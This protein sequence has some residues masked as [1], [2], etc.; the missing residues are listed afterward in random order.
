MNRHLILVYGT[1]RRGGSNAI[2]RLFPGSRFVGRAEVAG[3]LYD[4][5]EYPALLQGDP[6]SLVIGEVYEVDDFTLRSLDEFEATADYV[7]RKAT[8]N[9]GGSATPCWYYGPVPESCEG[10]QSIDSGDW[11]E[12]VRR[13]EQFSSQRP[14]DRARE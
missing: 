1:L 13:G 11:I 8:V 2:E 9:L 6:V 10:K 7:R 3:R 4:L 12:H 5:G 14:K